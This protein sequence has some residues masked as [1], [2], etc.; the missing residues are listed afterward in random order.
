MISSP[1][2]HQLLS[3]R[4]TWLSILRKILL[5]HIRS[6]MSSCMFV[7]VPVGPGQHRCQ[8]RHLLLLRLRFIS[9]STSP[10]SLPLRPWY[11]VTAY[12]GRGGARDWN[13]THLPLNTLSPNYHG[14]TK[15]RLSAALLFTDHQKYL[16]T[17][18]ADNCNASVLGNFCLWSVSWNQNYYCCRFMISCKTAIFT[19]VYR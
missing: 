4:Y 11:Y 18:S 9:S 3:S 14:P 6:L 2:L 13:G 19:C 16:K 12:G 8:H 10:H 1:T 15:C 5:T 7:C 17:S